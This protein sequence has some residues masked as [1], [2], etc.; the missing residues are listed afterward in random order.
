MACGKSFDFPGGGRVALG[1]IQ[2]CH[3]ENGSSLHNGRLGIANVCYGNGPMRA[4]L[5]KQPIT[6]QEQRCFSAESPK[7]GQEYCFPPEKEVR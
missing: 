4:K 1:C 5:P 2:G 6:W 3:R 7:D